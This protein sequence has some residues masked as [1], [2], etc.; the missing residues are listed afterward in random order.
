MTTAIPTFTSVFAT[1]LGEYVALMVNIGRAFRVEGTILRAFDRFVSERGHTG[2]LTQ[3]LVLDFVY[4]VPDLM[5]TQYAKRHQIIRRF[6]QY[7]QHF[8]PA[9]E[10][11]GLFQR[12]ATP[13][14]YQAHV[15]TAEELTCLLDAARQLPPAHSLRSLTY[16]TILGLI[17]S[18]G[19]RDGEVLALD[20]DAVDLTEGVLHI[21]CTKF[22]KSRLVPVHATT[23]EVL[24]EYDQVR[25]T[26]FPQPATPA[27]FV[28]T[29]GQRL[30]YSTL[31]SVFLQLVRALG[32]RNAQGKGPRI[33]DMRHTFAI[34]RVQAWYDDG[35]DVQQQCPV[36]ATYLGH[37][38]FEDTTYYLMAGAELMA[39]GAERFTREGRRQ[40]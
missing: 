29:R 32:I 13:Q 33:H 37:A 2:P 36:L 4:S 9:T 15:Y 21:R 34:R 12:T 24:R 40:S 27:F 19:M 3:A 31:A 38:H 22:R 18:T 6:A 8:E 16:Y 30:A 10:I 35:E 5:Q 11:P 1:S 26:A 14:R 25:R 20:T 28:N 23:L 17:A 7:L 39:K